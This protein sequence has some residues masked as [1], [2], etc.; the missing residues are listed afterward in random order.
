[1]NLIGLRGRALVLVQIISAAGA[2]CQMIFVRGKASVSALH[3]PIRR[4]VTGV[5]RKRVTGV[6]GQ[7]RERGLL[8]GSMVGE[9]SVGG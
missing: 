1:M 4:E 7:T 6:G 9:T 8:L 5:S 2:G 3:R